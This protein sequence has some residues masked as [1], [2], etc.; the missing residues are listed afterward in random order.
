MKVV[1]GTMDDMQ[2]DIIINNSLH[3]SND[4]IINLMINTIDLNKK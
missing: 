1:D 2:W 4:L 3:K